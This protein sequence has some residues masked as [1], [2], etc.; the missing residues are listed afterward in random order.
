[1]DRLNLS[2]LLELSREL[3]MHVADYRPRWLDGQL[4]ELWYGRDALIE[5]NKMIRLQKT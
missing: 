4:D 2:L 1:M 5:Q 3:I